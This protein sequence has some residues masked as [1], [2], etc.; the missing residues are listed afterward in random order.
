MKFKIP[1]G[2]MLV[3][4]F[5]TGV[6]LVE[7]YLPLLAQVNGNDN[8][9]ALSD[10]GFGWKFPVAK[11]PSTG[12]GRQVTYSDIRDPGGIPQGLPVRLLIPAIGV[13]SVIEDALITPD[14]RMDVPAGSRNVAWFALGPH[15]G[16]V[17]SAVIGGHFGINNNLP[18]V[19]YNLNKLNGGDKIYV[20]DDN[21]KTLVFL[22][23]SISS[24]DRNADATTV[25]TSNDGIAHLNLITCEGVWNETNGTYPLRLVVFTDAV[26]VRNAAETIAAFPRTL[27][28]GA[29]G[30]DV[31]ALQTF[32]E[33][34]GFLIVPSGIAKGFFGS[35][36]R[37]AIA[38]YQIG[39]G[40]L[41]DGIFGQSTRAKLISELESG[42]VL[43]ST[44]IE[45]A[46][47][48]GGTRGPSS[49]FQIVIQFVKDYL[50]ATPLDGLITSILVI[51]IV[52]TVIKI[53]LL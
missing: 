45:K 50:Y 5:L 12:S 21:G 13:D 44:G 52:F 20:R 2:T 42:P 24:F 28:I 48:S 53:V 47:T 36:T 37:A 31:V 8:G 25:F 4:I 16:Q 29:R 19:F 39:V 35:L 6:M 26:P 38:K 3:V 14:G 1:I 7:H 32:L 34:K 23:R 49:S 41:S 18:F 33:Q 46:I 9:L 27:D 51:L 15:P 11:F 17:G 43:P 10:R 22:V 40:L 30:V